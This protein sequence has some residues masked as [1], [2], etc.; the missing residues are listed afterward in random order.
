MPYTRDYDFEVGQTANP[1]EVDSELNKLFG[2]V[3]AL[4]S[5]IHAATKVYVDG[6]HALQV[7]KAGDT[8]TGMLKFKYANPG[9]RL[10]GTEGSGKDYFIQ[11]NAGNITIFR[12]DGL[13]DSPSLVPVYQFRSD[14]LPLSDHDVA[15]KVYVDYPSWVGNNVVSGSGGF[16][17]GST[18]FVDITGLS[19]PFTLTRVKRVYINFMGFV[20]NDALGKTHV[21][22][23]IDDINQGGCVCTGSDQNASFSFMSQQLG[24]G[25]HTTKMQMKVESGNGTMVMNSDFPVRFSVTESPFL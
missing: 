11:E 9:I 4:E 15:R 5:N 2:A 18:G 8:I 16:T 13:E 3:N 17:T 22:C 21:R 7:L 23:L 14:G 19:L 25:A 24:V 20:N 10:L 12:N 1:D 6:L